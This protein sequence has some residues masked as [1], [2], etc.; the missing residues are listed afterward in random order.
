M[1]R[2]TAV[3]EIIK[4]V[5]K[6][7]RLAALVSICCFLL[8]VST[9]AQEK[10]VSKEYFKLDNGLKVYLM[11]KHTL[12][13]VHCVFAV[14]LGSKNETEETNGLVHILEHYILFRGTKTR[15]GRSIG[16]EMRSHGA[17]FNAHTG[18]DLSTYEISLP[19]QH[20]NF[21]LQSLKEI[22]FDLEFRQEPLDEEKQVILEEIN[23]IKD[24]PLKYG[25]MLLY[26]NLF[27]DHPYHLPIIGQRDIIE[28]ASIEKLEEFYR[29]YFHPPNSS[30]ALVG[31]FSLA[32]MKAQ[33]EAI[34]GSLEAGEFTPQKFENV[35]PLKKTEEIQEVMD[36]KTGY[37]LIGM[38][39]PDYNNDDQYAMD[40]LSEALGRGL[41]PMLYH[42]LSR[43]R[44]RLS[45]M[46]MG[47]SAYKYGGAVTIVLTLDPKN[48]KTARREIIQYLKNSRRLNYSSKDVFGDDQFYATDYMEAAKNRIKFQGQLAQERGLL[49]AH[50]LASFMLVDDAQDRGNY[51]ENIDAV[52]SS[53]LRQAAGKY[54]SQK[55]YVV[56]SI[57]PQKD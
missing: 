51:L 4:R 10:K 54:L 1:G 50:S 15:N 52:T 27:Q 13:L 2:K 11:E 5:N 57:T 45:S 46:R 7:I 18:W 21:A 6:F 22:L 39:A 35:S 14:N 43:R 32:E 16:Q 34:F 25:S 33:V 17:Y 56:I 12:P 37:L 40:V 47:Y 28:S 55:G 36:V 9:P 8:P 3:F 26:Q 31:S 29:G 20:V 38:T 49:I 41:N 53:D 48:L 24:D 19:S 30:L 23:Q 44:I 42:P